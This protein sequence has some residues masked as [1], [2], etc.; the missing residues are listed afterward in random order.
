MSLCHHVS[1]YTLL[2]GLSMPVQMKKKHFL[3]QDGN[4]T[5]F[6]YQS[7][8]VLASLVWNSFPAHIQHCSSL[9]NFRASL[10][11]F[12]FCLLCAALAL[13][14][15]LKLCLIL[16]CFAAYVITGWPV[17]IAGLCVS[18]VLVCSVIVN[19]NKRFELLWERAHY[20]CKFLW[21]LI[22]RRNGQWNQH[23]LFLTLD[24]NVLFFFLHYRQGHYWR[25]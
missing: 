5:A 9:T 12:L 10:K 14:Q 3:V 6:G 2:L 25:D 19:V 8:S 15:V 1:L 4:W 21:L 24:K 20:K 22:I 23:V 13:S 11:T 18:V 17:I 7:F 16:F